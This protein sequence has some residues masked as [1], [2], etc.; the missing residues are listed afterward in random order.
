MK[1]ILILAVFLSQVTHAGDFDITQRLSEGD[2]ISAD[3][4][5]DILDYI[6]LSLATVNSEDLV[7]TWDIVQT[8]NSI[9]C[10]GSGNIV[11]SLTGAS[12]PVDSI[13]RQRSDEVTFTSDGDGT[14][15]FLQANYCSFFQD[16]GRG[17]SNQACGN[18]FAMVDGRFL[19]SADGVN[20]AYVAEK[21][22]RTRIILSLWAGGSQSF[23]IIRLDKKNLPPSSPTSLNATISNGVV[24]LNWTAPAGTVDSY[25]VMSKDSVEGSYTELVSGIGAVTYTDSL[26]SGVTRWYR[27]FAVNQYGESTGSNVVNITAE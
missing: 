10:L 18:N 12:S 14:Y 8:T 15:S 3:V 5:N 4:F 26:N 19:L 11:C 23:N 13:Y 25:K 17:S 16:D 7:G 22:S 20:L 21:K 24:T 6:E 1:K 9:G 27:V 2:V